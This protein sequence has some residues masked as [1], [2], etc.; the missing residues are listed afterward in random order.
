MSRR[1]CTWKAPRSPTVWSSIGTNSCSIYPIQSDRSEF[2]IRLRVDRLGQKV[3]TALRFLPPDGATRAFEVHG[4]PGLV[5]LD[6]PLAPSRAALCRVRLLAYS[7]RRRPPAVPV[8]P[9][10]PVPA[11]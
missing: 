10:N 6:P 9:G 11:A 1:V 4:D 7:R 5:R 8:L 3:S 2:A